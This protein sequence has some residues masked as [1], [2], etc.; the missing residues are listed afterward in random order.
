MELR[1]AWQSLIHSKMRALVALAGI[2]FAINL[3]FIQL[4]LYDAV[5]DAG[6]LIQDRLN[7]DL[8]LVS[9]HYRFLGK[10]GSF[11]RRRLVE[12]RGFPGVESAVPLYVGVRPWRNESSR[13]DWQI[14]VLGFNP[15][16]PVFRHPEIEAQLPAL[17]QPDTVLLDRDTRAE[18]GSQDEGT[19]TELGHRKVRVVGQY[20]LGF[21]FLALGAVVTTDQSYSR[22]FQGYPLQDVNLGLVKL[23]PGADLAECA[24][25]LRATVGPEVRVLTRAELLAA[26]RKYWATQS[27]VGLI[28]G[29]GALVAVI[30]G[31]VILY[32]VL[33]SDIASSLPQYAMLKAIGYKDR[34]L[35][36]V[37]LF[38]V[39]ILGVLAY[40]PAVLGALVGYEAVRAQAKLPIEMTVGRVLAVLV[41]TLMMSGVTGLVCTRKLRTADPADLY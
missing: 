23:K 19:V 18:Y 38:K 36:Q 1:I 21:G 12:A 7:F 2:S 32:Q 27:S 24:R 41:L 6:T 14:L 26:E 30:V 33:A 8:V 31:I 9:P 17:K 5:L 40:V 22:F 20:T 4:G 37:V 39:G 29:F 10:T 34:S 25:A 28:N 35:A 16:D 3:I 13:L 11:P 15:E